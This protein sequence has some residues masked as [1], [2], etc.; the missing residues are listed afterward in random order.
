MQPKPAASNA[1]SLKSCPAWL[2]EWL[3]VPSE[4]RKA[5]R[6]GRLDLL[7]RGRLVV[8]KGASRETAPCPQPTPRRLGAEKVT[9]DTCPVPIA[10]CQV[11]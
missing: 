10:A 6:P 5:N 2:N 8:G 3:A 9:P 11:A 7:N 1:H 4:L